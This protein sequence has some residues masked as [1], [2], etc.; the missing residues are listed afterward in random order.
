MLYLIYIV[1]ILLLMPMISIHSSVDRLFYIILSLAL[2]IAG[3]F[4][5]S[6][7]ADNCPFFIIFSDLFSL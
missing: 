7:S 1:I 4:I 3:I 5:G 6:S 2:P